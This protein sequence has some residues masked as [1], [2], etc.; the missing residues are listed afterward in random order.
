LASVAEAPLMAVFFNEVENLPP[1]AYRDVMER[2]RKYQHRVTQMFK[3][4]VARDMLEDLD[5]ELVVFGILGMG[6][7]MHRWYRPQGRKS[8]D[9]IAQLFSHIVL[10]GI[11][12]RPH[13]P[14]S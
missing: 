12:K 7:W 14:H 9:Q 5:A 4:G 3:E 13:H 11:R 10:E 8:L 6:N 1:D 2:M